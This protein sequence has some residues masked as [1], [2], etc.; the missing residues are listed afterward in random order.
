MKTKLKLKRNLKT[1]RISRINWNSTFFLNEQMEVSLSFKLMQNYFLVWWELNKK[2]E[3][4]FHP[5][6]VWLCHELLSSKHNTWFDTWTYI[7]DTNCGQEFIMIEQ[8]L[9]EIMLQ[10]MIFLTGGIYSPYQSIILTFCRNWQCSRLYKSNLQIQRTRRW[11]VRGDVGSSATPSFRGFI[12]WSCLLVPELNFDMSTACLS[13][14]Q[15]PLLKRTNFDMQF[16]PNFI[17]SD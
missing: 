1:K 9:C 17:F 4:V 15:L 12:L 6:L 2:E 16:K 3:I 10:F 8:L 5:E 11:R 13:L 14:F 7:L